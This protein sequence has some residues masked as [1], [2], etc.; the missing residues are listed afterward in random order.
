[1]TRTI[2]N[3]PHLLAEVSEAV[4][5]TFEL[6]CGEVTFEVEPDE[7]VTAEQLGTVLR[8]AD[9]SASIAEISAR[10]GL[11]EDKLATVLL[12]AQIS[13]L[14]DDRST[15]ATE[16]ALVVLGAV[17]HVVNRLLEE[18]VFAGP[19]WEAILHK[20]EQV[21]PHVYY[22]FGLENWFFLSRECE[23]DS[24][25]LA[26]PTSDAIRSMANDFYHEEHRHDDIVVQAFENLGITRQALVAARPLP[27]TSGLIKLLSWWART[28]PLFFIATIG[29]LEGRLEKAEGEGANYDSFLRACG[30]AGI[31]PHFVEPMRRHAKVNASH[32]H[33]SVSREFFAALPPLPVGTL[34]RLVGKAHLFVE[35]YAEFFNG[36][37][38]Y[39]SDSARP[40]VRT[41]TTSGVADVRS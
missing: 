31:A 30:I 7:G 23:F 29:I 6:R 40:L 16:S 34:E 18:L 33:G 17:E 41:G 38:D 20:P 28:D 32:D 1:M 27:T 37:L 12:P 13:G 26:Y 2:P 25:I 4:P 39:Y 5:G 35:A 9:G 21:D 10:S 14:L 19:F 24:A 3:K 22:G 15:P 11:P 8:A 36:I